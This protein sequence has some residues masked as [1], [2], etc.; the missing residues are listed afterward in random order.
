MKE[1][2]REF[3]VSDNIFYIFA[4]LAI[5]FN[6]FIGIIDFAQG[7]IYTGCMAIACSVAMIFLVVSYIR[8][9][10][11]VMKGLIGVVLTLCFSYKLYI[12]VNASTTA[13]LIINIIMLACI[14]FI[15]VNHFIINSD[16]HS[17]PD[18]IFHSQ[19]MAFIYFVFTVILL[20]VQIAIL[21]QDPSK[22]VLVSLFWLA[23]VAFI[24]CIETKLDSFRISREEK[25]WTE[26]R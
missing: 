15:L 16:H 17:N 26:S 25:G 10:K 22:A 3:F 1:K 8:H 9:E 4:L 12:T 7:Q 20:I 14:L 13:E 6:L 24:I 5:G 2:L 11:N 18:K 21:K 23:T 19:L